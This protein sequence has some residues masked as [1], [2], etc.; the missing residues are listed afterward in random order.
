MRSPHPAAVIFKSVASKGIGNKGGRLSG[1]PPFVCPGGCGA[2]RPAPRPGCP[3]LP[4]ALSPPA[5]PSP[6]TI[7]FPAT[8]PFPVFRVGCFAG[9]PPSRSRPSP[10]RRLPPGFYALSFPA[11]GC[12]AGCLSPPIALS[13]VGRQS[14][15]LLSCQ[16]CLFPPVLLLLSCR[17]LVPLPTFPLPLFCRAPIPRLARFLPPVGR[18]PAAGALGGRRR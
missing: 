7:P 1:R 9:S 12:P 18:L 13:P 2:L 6:P 5:T 16:G 15:S 17:M 11:P 14:R 3:S 4:A 8:R 10:A